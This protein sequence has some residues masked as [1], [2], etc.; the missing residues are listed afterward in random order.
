MSRNPFNQGHSIQRAFKSS[1]SVR[2]LLI[3]RNPFNQGHSIQSSN[4]GKSFTIA[5][6]KVAILLI[7]VIQFR[8]LM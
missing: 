7:K 3:S 1:T 6:E 2:V 8:G 5:T 4:R